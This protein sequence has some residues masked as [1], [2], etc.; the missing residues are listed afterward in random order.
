[1]VDQWED[2]VVVSVEEVEVSFLEEVLGEECPGED[3]QEA[4]CSRELGTGSVPMG[5][6]ETR[7]LLGGRSAIS[8]KHQ[9]QKA[10][11]DPLRSLRK[12]V[13]AAG[14]ALEVPLVCAEAEGWTV[15][16]L[17]VALEVPPEASVEAE[18]VIVGVDSEEGAVVWSEVVSEAG[19]A[20]DLLWTIWAAEAEGGG[21]GPLAR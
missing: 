2:V 20:V 3:R 1:M 7:T 11:E 6:V 12:V 15:A 10:L 8:V 19:D 17:G 9:D 4:I 16:D 18:A 13:S 21:W 14:V 5:V